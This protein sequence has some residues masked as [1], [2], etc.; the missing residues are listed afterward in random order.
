MYSFVKPGTP[1]PGEKI[2]EAD[3]RGE[4]VYRGRFGH[5]AFA[6]VNAKNRFGGYVGEKIYLFMCLAD[7]SIIEL[8]YIK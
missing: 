3:W 6:K 8:P 1:V 2:G 7:G 4:W 5:I